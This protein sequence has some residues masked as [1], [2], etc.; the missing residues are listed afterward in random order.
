VREGVVVVQFERLIR[1]YDAP[2]NA[3][4]AQQIP[5]SSNSPGSCS[6]GFGICKSF[7]EDGKHNTSEKRAGRAEMTDYVIF[8]GLS[9]RRGDGSQGSSIIALVL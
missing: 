6:F 3:A 4:H 8:V 5:L 7:G 2:N 1:L 9:G